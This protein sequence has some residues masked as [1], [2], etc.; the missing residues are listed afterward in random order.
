MVNVGKV[1]HRARKGAGVLVQMARVAVKVQEVR[2][3]VP[4]NQDRR[5]AVNPKTSRPQNQTGL[6]ESLSLAPGPAS[7][8][9]SQLG[10][11]LLL[12]PAVAAR[13]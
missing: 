6:F 1:P 2:V 9:P 12:N 5:M 8:G 4:I 11:G 13:S 7:L 3:A 10:T